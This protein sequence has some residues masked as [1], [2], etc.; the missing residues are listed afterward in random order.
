[1]NAMDELNISPRTIDD[2]NREL[3]VESKRV[4]DGW[5]WHL[6]S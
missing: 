1:M 2:A 6:E 5:L 3:G 4:K